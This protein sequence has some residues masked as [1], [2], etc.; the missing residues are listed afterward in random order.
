MAS[1]CEWVV[2]GALLGRQHVQ[3]WG[4]VGKTAR[5]PR[6]RCHFTCRMTDLAPRRQSL[7]LAA[8]PVNAAGRVG[9]PPAAVC[10]NGV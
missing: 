8:S 2:N 9:R 4:P 6:T 3:Q 10:A 5:H 1:A 7:R